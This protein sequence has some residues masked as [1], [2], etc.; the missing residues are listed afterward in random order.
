MSRVNQLANL[1][2]SVKNK[3]GLIVVCGVT[4]CLIAHPVHSSLL[5]IHRTP[6]LPINTSSSP[7]ERPIG[8]CPS[9]SECNERPVGLCPSCSECNE[10]PIGLRPSCSECKERPIGLCP[11]CSECNERPVG[12]C[13]SCSE[14]N[15]RPI[16]S[17]FP[18][19]YSLFGSFPRATRAS[20]RLVRTGVAARVQ[21]FGAVLLPHCN[22][23]PLHCFSQCRY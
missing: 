12:L 17:A 20:C 15:E 5:M 18:A 11:S 23:P 8:L 1:A 7:R 21:E 3:C 6:S 19:L 2:H 9:C 10:R 16:S 4:F 22:L 13:P 14:C